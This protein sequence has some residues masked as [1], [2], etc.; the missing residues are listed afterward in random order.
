[1]KIGIIG[2]GNM[3]RSLGLLWAEQGHEVFFGARTKEKGQSIAEFVANGT[4]GGTNDQAAN[5]GDVLLYTVRGINPAEVLTSIEV[6]SGKILIDCNNFEI[7]TGFAFSPIVQSLAE[8]LAAEVPN[9]KVVKAF[10]TMAQEV[11]E[12]APSPL[13]DYH[14]SV[15]ICGDDTQARQTVMQLAQDIGFAAVDCGELRHARLVEGLGDFIRLM[16]I[17]QLQNPYATISVNILPAASAQRLG[18]RQPSEL[19]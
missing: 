1:M 5:F 16:I 17:G 10:N 6:L 19:S 7:P 4:Q 12:L 11:F 14:V 18:G 2:S 9:A 15:F 3:G 8:K 13:F